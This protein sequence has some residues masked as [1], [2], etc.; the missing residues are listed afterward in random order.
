MRRFPRDFF[1]LPLVLLMASA[2]AASSQGQ[3]EAAKVLDKFFDLGLHEA[4]GGKWVRIFTMDSEDG[5]AMPGAGNAQYSGN[6]WLV[7]EEHG[8]IDAIMS[9]GRVLRGKK[10]KD[11]GDDPRDD[12]D[13]PPLQIQPANLD[14]DLKI[15]TATLK[16]KDG[17]RFSGDEN[18]QAQMKER[19]AGGAL[20][21]LAQLQRQGRGD[22]V[23]EALPLVLASVPSPEMALDGAVSLIADSQLALLARTWV[24]N[25]D[26][27]AYAEG[28]A[29]VVANFPRGWKIREAALLLSDGLRAQKS[30]PFAAESDA[31]LAAGLLLK[32]KPAQFR[33]LPIGRNW[34]IHG[35]NGGPPREFPGSFPPDDPDEKNDVGISAKKKQGC[36]IFFQQARRCDG[37]REAA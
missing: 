18:T 10:M 25:G 21:F 34:F 14:G 17:G 29:K 28:I 4:K 15:F 20:L 11:E 30:S 1:P 37:P 26:A 5:G 33:E 19:I 23:N 36:C 32:L 16:M 24:E 27:S 3:P 31:R 6:A 8:V 7:R 9:D 13:L 2:T 22:F 12:E 35:L